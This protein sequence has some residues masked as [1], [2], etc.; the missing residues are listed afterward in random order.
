MMDVLEG[1]EFVREFRATD[2]ASF[3]VGRDTGKRYVVHAKFP[4]I[5][6]SQTKLNNFINYARNEI[7]DESTA[8]DMASFACDCYE[9]S[10]RQYRN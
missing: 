8:V 10:L 5:T 2:G 3:E 1:L 9:R 6:G 4:Y 7:Q